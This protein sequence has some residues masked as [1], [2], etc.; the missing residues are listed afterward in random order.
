MNAKQQILDWLASHKSTTLPN[1]LKRNPEILQWVVNQTGQYPVKN[2]MERVYIVLNGAPEKCKNGHYRKFN[3]F[4]LG[5]RP[6]CDLGNRCK[7]IA[8]LRKVNQ[9]KTLLERYGV[10]STGEIPGTLEKRQ[11]TNLSKYGAKYAMQNPELKAKR[12]KAI[13][14]KPLAEKQLIR[15]QIKATNLEKYGVDHHMKLKSQQQ[16]AVNTNLQRYGV[17]YPL[18]HPDF[19]KKA[20]DTIAAI[21]EEQKQFAKDKQQAYFKQ[22]YGVN[23]PSQILLGPETL[24]VLLNKDKF[25]CAITNKTRSQVVNELGISD[26]T[27]YLYAK[28]YQA[29]DLFSRPLLSSFEEEVSEFIN[30]ELGIPTQNNRRDIIPPK[31]I[32]IYVPSLNIAIEC[33]G[34]YWHSEISANKDRKYHYLKY[35]ECLDKGIT[36]ITVFED[37][38][39]L[40]KEKVKSRLMHRLVRSKKLHARKCVVSTL[41]KSVATSFINT[42]HLQGNVNAKYFYGLFYN[43]ELVSVMSFGPSRYNKQY[44]YEIHRFCSSMPVVGAASKLLTAFIRDHNPESIISYSDNRW[45][46]GKTYEHLGMTKISETIGYHY[47][48]YKQRF[49]RVKF[50]KHKLKYLLDNFDAA[51]SEW[52]N[53][54]AHNYDRIW[55]CGQSLWVWKSR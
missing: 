39:N 49:D 28:Q 29:T 33:C 12:I 7:C 51:K 54:V 55:D 8:E 43:N 48:D 52:E 11:Q 3:T 9:Q 53:M 31:E 18:Q 25:I 24:S 13:N 34:L 26:T 5:Y 50:Q 15:S 44:Q 16:K 6:G 41:S 32:D 46:N 2:V 20:K 35:K 38:W 1:W 21:P 19:A 23:A 30:N 45:G 42:Y 4:E 40:N 22:K 17:C 37:E 14:E 10:K 27:L 47:T 36:L